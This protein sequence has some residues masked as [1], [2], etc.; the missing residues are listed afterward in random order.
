M[1]IV[2]KFYRHYAYVCAF[3]NTI[4]TYYTRG[5]ALINENNKKKKT[6]CTCGVVSIDGKYL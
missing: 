6:F 1:K 2:D 5:S 3:Y 4:S